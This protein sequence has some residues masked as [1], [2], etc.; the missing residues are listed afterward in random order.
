MATL[1]MRALL[2]AAVGVAGATG[3]DPASPSVKLARCCIGDWGTGARRACSVCLRSTDG[4]TQTQHSELLPLLPLPSSSFAPVITVLSFCC[5]VHLIATVHSAAGL[6][7]Q[8]RC[9]CLSHCALC[10][11]L[12]ASCVVC[13]VCSGAVWCPEKKNEE[14]RR[15]ID[16]TGRTLTDRSAVQIRGHAVER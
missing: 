2:P 7:S 13:G 9:A 16:H 5:P 6:S 15:S 3:V 1:L 14:E 12:A 8:P 4:C 10:R 11:R